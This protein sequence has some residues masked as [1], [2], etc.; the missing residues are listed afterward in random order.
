MAIMALYLLFAS[1][2]IIHLVWVSRRYLR[3][4]REP[5][6]GQC[7]PN[8]VYTH[9]L[10]LGRRSRIDLVLAFGMLFAVACINALAVFL[11][12]PDQ[13]PVSIL[14]LCFGYNIDDAGIM[15]LGCF[16]IYW[17][18]ICVWSFWVGARVRHQVGTIYFFQKELG[19]EA[20]FIDRPNIAYE[21]KYVWV[22]YVVIAIIV[23]IL[24]V[25]FYVLY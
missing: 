18:V 12:L 21:P 11:P 3:L 9:L 24:L 8:K 1:S 6:G 14:R 16:G 5:L 23:A 15:T 22:V 13:V 17:G 25:T 20:L 10:A 4:L 19:V 7:I 2:T